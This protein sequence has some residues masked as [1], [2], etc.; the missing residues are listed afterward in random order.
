MFLKDSLFVALWVSVVAPPMFAQSVAETSV[1]LSVGQ[2]MD[3]AIQTNLTTHLARAAS[4][5]ARG[6][7]IQA[8]ASLLPQLTGSVAQERVFKANLAAEGFT[9]NPL[10]PNPVIGPFNV[11][12]AR[13]QLVQSL[14]DVN[15]IWLTKAASANVQ[16]ARLG[17]DLAAEQV[18]SAAALAYIEDFRAI[19]D[20]QDAQSN[21]EL[22]QKLSTLAHHQHE[23]GLA[24]TVDSAR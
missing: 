6:R 19:R 21:V 3:K 7:V 2:A 17:E 1:A 11:F 14:L 10:I 12:D 16:V 20:V 9:S 15:S 22:A 18:A 8:A 5:Q 4:V 24:T 23:A 13:I